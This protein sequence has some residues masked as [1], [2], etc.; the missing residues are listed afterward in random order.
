MKKFRF[1]ILK[2]LVFGGE[3]F[4][5]LNRSVFVKAEHSRELVPNYF[6]SVERS[7]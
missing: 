5:Y 1:F 2:L 3:I 4:K 6:A 7:L